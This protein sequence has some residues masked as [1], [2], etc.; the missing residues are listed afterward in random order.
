MNQLDAQHLHNI[1][2]KPTLLSPA[3]R[4]LT[5]NRTLASAGKMQLMVDGALSNNAPRAATVNFSG[6][7]KSHQ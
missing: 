4:L 7:L 1:H 5:K 3:E 2:H 6:I